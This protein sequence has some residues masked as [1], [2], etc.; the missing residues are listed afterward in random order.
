MILCG[1]MAAQ[2]I[3][4]KYLTIEKN[5]GTAQTLT[6]V[7]LNI[8]YADGMLTATNGSE[9]ATLALI[10]ISRMFFTNT[11]DATA[12]ADITTI[13]DDGEA[14]VFD[15]AGRQV[16]EGRMQDVKAR[17]RRGVYIIKLNSKTLKVQ[18]K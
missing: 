10:D 5:D 14:A 18:V 6:A 17:L 3:D 11:K 12:I 7:G 9:S 15:L 13:T 2:A 1:T 4:Y 8:T 16:T